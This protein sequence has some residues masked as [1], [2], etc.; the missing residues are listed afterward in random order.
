MILYI[1]QHP[2]HYLAVPL[3]VNFELFYHFFVYEHKTLQFMSVKEKDEV[4]VIKT[5]WL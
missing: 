2:R 3:L 5:C 4:L 1:V